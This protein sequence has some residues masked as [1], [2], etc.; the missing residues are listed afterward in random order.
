VGDVARGPGGRQGPDLWRVAVG[1]A[2]A[3]ITLVND[4]DRDW[5][6]RGQQAC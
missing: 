1:Q 4:N 3:R 5:I 2:V 6:M